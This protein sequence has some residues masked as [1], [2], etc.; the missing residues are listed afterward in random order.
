MRV[1]V[2]GES[3]HL[4]DAT[5]LKDI[6][7]RLEIPPRFIAVEHN[8]EIYDGEPEACS[9]SDGDRLEIVRFVGGG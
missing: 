5:T 7:A 4:D 6:L 3:M 8:G 9:L 1:Q 2:N